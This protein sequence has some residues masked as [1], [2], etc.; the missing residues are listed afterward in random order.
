M[1]RGARSSLPTRQRLKRKIELSKQPANWLTI[2]I[3]GGD[4][5]HRFLQAFD[6]KAAAGDTILIIGHNVALMIVEFEEYIVRQSVTVI[7]KLD[8]IIQ[9]LTNG[10]E[11]VDDPG[12]LPGRTYN[13]LQQLADT[14]MRGDS[15]FCFRPPAR[16]HHHP[17]R[18]GIARR[19]GAA[20]LF[21]LLSF[22]F[23]VA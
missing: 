10:G 19:P 22:F 16:G 17:V 1:S 8:P 23:C 21:R 12:S 14:L 18:H 2:G 5:R 20:L 9:F 3:R 15:H 7:L 4:Q 13:I 11:P 6:V